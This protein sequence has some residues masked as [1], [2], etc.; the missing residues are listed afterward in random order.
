MKTSEEAL[1]LYAVRRTKDMKGVTIPS[2]RRYVHYVGKWMELGGTEPNPRQTLILKKIKFP[3]P[4]TNMILSYKIMK[5]DKELVYRSNEKINTNT[6]SNNGFIE[7]GCEVTLRDDIKLIIQ[8]KD[9]N[10]KK[11]LLQLWFNIDF[12][13]NNYAAFPKFE[14]DKIQKDKKNIIF[15]ADMKLELFFESPSRE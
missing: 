2:Q 14:L 10:L 8:R 5:Q 15:D 12:I 1:H 4:S 11:K 3:T 7:I 6:F 9:T 13:E